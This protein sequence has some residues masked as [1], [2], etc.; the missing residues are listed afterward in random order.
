MMKER[1]KMIRQMTREM[2]RD[3]EVKLCKV[4]RVVDSQV[5]VR[6]VVH[7]QVIASRGAIGN[8]AIKSKILIHGFLCVRRT[9]MCH[10]E[11]SV[12]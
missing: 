6:G 1:F 8:V 7:S 12:R 2:S 10:G 11:P 3:A 5:I 9:I 4:R